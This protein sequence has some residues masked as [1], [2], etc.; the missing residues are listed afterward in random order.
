MNKKLYRS[1][2]VKR[3][4][5][6]VSASVLGICRTSTSGGKEFMMDCKAGPTTGCVT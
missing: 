2:V 3:V 5:L 6:D 1:P 4:K